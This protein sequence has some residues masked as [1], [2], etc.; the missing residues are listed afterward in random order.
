MLF[1]TLGWGALLVSGCMAQAPF[2]MTNLGDIGHDDALYEEAGMDLGV[3]RAHRAEEG[4][5]IEGPDTGGL[6]WRVWLNPTHYRQPAYHGDFDGNGKPDLLVVQPLIGNGMCIDSGTF[7]FLMMDERGRPVPWEAD[8][9]GFLA[10]PEPGAPILYDSDGDGRA[11]LATHDCESHPIDGDKRERRWLTDVFEAKTGQWERIEPVALSLFEMAMRQRY[12]AYDFV[13][14]E[15]SPWEEPKEPQPLYEGPELTVTGILPGGWDGGRLRYSDGIVRKGW[16]AVIEDAP[17]GRE[18]HFAEPRWALDL[19]LQAGNPVRL[20]GPDEQPTYLWTTT[21]LKDTKQEPKPQATLSVLSS[22]AITLK[23]GPPEPPDLSGTAPMIGIEAAPP[24]GSVPT[25][26][27]PPAAFVH[28]GGGS[29]DS[30]APR[31]SPLAFAAL[32]RPGGAVAGRV[33]RPYGTY[34]SRGGRC[35]LQRGDSE[36]PVVHVLPDCTLFGDRQADAENGLRIYERGFL[37]ESWGA[38]GREVALEPSPSAPG[39]LIGAVSAPDGRFAQWAFG[40][41]TYFVY[42]D[43]EGVPLSEPVEAETSAEMLGS[44]RRGLT[45]LQWE[46]GLPVELIRAEISLE[47]VR[48]TR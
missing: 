46:D 5:L 16:P 9:Q 15:R 32:L 25:P 41:R 23:E 28:S 4:L 38:P 21:R 43:R 31:S 24:E 7:L 36:E 45:L 3:A 29:G 18:I 27:I 44:D 40:G 34:F 8:S 6:P 1:R 13:D 10:K 2:P 11:E 26:V 17:E 22:V 30:T 35:F 37:D 42:H 12:E 20:I 14:F 47:W 19:L 39:E 33:P 48:A